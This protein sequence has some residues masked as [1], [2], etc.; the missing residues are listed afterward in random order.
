MPDG[1]RW[2]T[3]AD[4]AQS[5]RVRPGT[6]RVWVHRELVRSHRILGRTY[7]CLD[8]VA[9]AEVAWRRRAMRVVDLHNGGL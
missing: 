5:Q 7:V 9:D 6:I 2:A 4:A 3:V 1:T 8:D